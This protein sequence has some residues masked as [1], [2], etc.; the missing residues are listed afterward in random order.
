MAA[1]FRSTSATESSCCAASLVLFSKPLAENK[2]LHCTATCRLAN[3]NC[4]SGPLSTY[5]RNPDA[6]NRPVIIISNAMFRASLLAVPESARSPNR[7]TGPFSI[8]FNWG[9][10]SRPGT[11]LRLIK[12]RESSSPS[13]TLQ[14]NSRSSRGESPARNVSKMPL[15]LGVDH[16]FYSAVVFP[17][18]VI[19]GITEISEPAV[20]VHELAYQFIEVVRFSSH[21]TSLLARGC[22]HTGVSVQLDAFAPGQCRPTG[23]PWL[24]SRISYTLTE[25]IDHCS[26][27]VDQ[28]PCSWW[29][30]HRQH[31]R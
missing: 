8:R 6:T 1:S 16:T 12:A 17:H 19:A 4:I 11:C 5:G 31:G 20:H 18:S 24:A 27:W 26:R 13:T 21:A 22:R 28:L 25:R 14:K 9:P 2:R 10:M 29:A 15:I 23:E 3:S 7:S 30:Y